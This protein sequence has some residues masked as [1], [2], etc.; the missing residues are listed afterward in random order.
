[1]NFRK[2]LLLLLMSVASSFTAQSSQPNLEELATQ[3]RWVELRAAA[4]KNNKA[5]FYRAIA[6]AVFNEPEAESLFKAV[7]RIEPSSDHSYEAYNWLANL[8][9]KSGRYHSL[10]LIRQAQ[11]KAFPNKE[12]IASQQKEDAPFMSLPDQK[13]G[14]RSPFTFHHDGHSLPAPATI[15][16]KHVEFFFDNGAD[17]SVI[18]EDEAKRLGMIFSDTSGSMGT[19]TN[20]VGF[21]MATAKDVAI[22]KMHFKDVSFAV[23]PDQKEPMSLMP[24]DRRGIIGLPLMVAIGT[25]HWEANGTLTIGEEPQRLVT[26]QSNLIFDAGDHVLL[27]ATFQGQP[28]WT[29]FD[30]GASTTDIYAPFARRFSDYLQNNGKTGN[31]QIIGLGGSE[32]YDSIDIPALPLE[33]AGKNLT[34]RPAHI[35]TKHQNY[36]DWIFANIGK[37]LYMQTS[38]FTL[39]LQAMRLE[40]E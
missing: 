7:I 21:R 33:I 16:G 37:D 32:N 30:S 26:E 34:L 18:S 39:D 35:M 25:F 31:N 36:R 8:Y 19:M 40:L 38:G 29:T 10:A 11:W 24:L 23:F 3:R 28:I 1:M 12:A 15:N 9:Q 17:L 13:N 4:A 20:S 5:R 2:P 27:Q 22:G 6:A 14:P